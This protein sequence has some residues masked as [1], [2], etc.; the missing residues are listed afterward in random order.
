MEGLRILKKTRDIKALCELSPDDFESVATAIDDLVVRKRVRHCVTENER[1]C[2]AVDALEAGDLALL[3]RL[4]G[5]SH[6]SLRDDYAVTGAELDALYEEA[7]VAP[8]CLGAR[9]TG[10]G[11]GGCAIAIVHRDSVKAFIERVGARYAARTGL[12]A[13]FFACESGDGVFRL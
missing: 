5:E 13:G 8:G 7:I 6:V 9:M 10:A 3:G 12:E 1:V 2:K 4:L 11:F